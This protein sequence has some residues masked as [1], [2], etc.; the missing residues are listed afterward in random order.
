MYYL[1][2][3]L[4]N[5]IVIFVFVLQRKEDERC[6]TAEKEKKEKEERLNELKKPEG[7]QEQVEKEEDHPL[8]PINN[9]PDHPSPLYCGFYSQPGQ[10]W[11]SMVHTHREILCQCINMSQWVSFMKCEQHKFVCSL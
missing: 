9:I 7:E 8:P 4:H 1:K 11:L 3:Q 6:Q 2:L 10:F 5:F